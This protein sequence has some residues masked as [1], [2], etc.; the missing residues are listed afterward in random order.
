MQEKLDEHARL[1]RLLLQGQEN[2]EEGDDDDED[3]EYFDW[4][5]YEA[6]LEQWRNEM[7]PNAAARQREIE[8]QRREHALAV[9]MDAT[10]RSAMG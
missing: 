3:L 6:R 10:A 7:Y 5:A 4:D 8:Q 9:T 2:E 1:S